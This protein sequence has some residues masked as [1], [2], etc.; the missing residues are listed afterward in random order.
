M[1]QQTKNLIQIATEKPNTPDE[2]KE[3]MAPEEPTSDDASEKE[4]KKGNYKKLNKSAAGKSAGK[5]TSMS[6]KLSDFS[7]QHFPLKLRK[8]GEPKT[9]KTLRKERRVKKKERKEVMV[10]EDKLMKRKRNWSPMLKWMISVVK[11]AETMMKYKLVL[12]PVQAVLSVPN[13]IPT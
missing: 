1:G 5:L 10:K 13:K 3:R 6:N 8:K 11:I 2:P 7:I 12:K 9:K 4:G